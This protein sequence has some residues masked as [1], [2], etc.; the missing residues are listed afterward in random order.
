LIAVRIS[1]TRVNSGW[2]KSSGTGT[3]RECKA[4]SDSA[5]G[6]EVAPWISI[7]TADV[8]LVANTSCVGSSSGSNQAVG[9]VGDTKSATSRSGAYSSNIVTCCLLWAKKSGSFV[10]G[11]EL[12]FV[13]TR[14]FFE[15]FQ[16]GVSQN[17]GDEG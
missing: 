5:W 1:E 3:V 2:C 4:C 17:E 10:W 7:V 11:N 16:K 15:V 13:Q 12:E 6:I 8:V 14:S 9:V